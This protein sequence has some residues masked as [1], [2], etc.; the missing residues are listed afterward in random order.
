[1]KVHADATSTPDSSLPLC[2]SPSLTWN[3]VEGE[4]VLFNC[5]T[6][7]YHAL[8]HTASRIWCC[9]A[10]GK[11]YPEIVASCMQQYDVDEA[12]IK[13]EINRFLSDSVTQGLLTRDTSA[14]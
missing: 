2:I 5:D 1:M 3:D 7:S 12:F 13:E 11:N 9:L 14:S 10:S 6:G 4:L 8:N